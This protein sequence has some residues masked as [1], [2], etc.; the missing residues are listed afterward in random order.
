MS[1]QGCGAATAS[2]FFSKRLSCQ[3]TLEDD[4][5]QPWCRPW[6]RPPLPVHASSSCSELWASAGLPCSGRQIIALMCIGG[7]LLLQVGGLSPKPCGGGFKSA[8][9]CR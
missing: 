9:A 2:C 4:T 3:R 7:L 1:Q 6:G 8:L 5:R